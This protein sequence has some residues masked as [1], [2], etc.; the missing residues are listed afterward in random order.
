MEPTTL[1]MHFLTSMPGERCLLML[2]ETTEAAPLE[3]LLDAACALLPLLDGTLSNAEWHSAEFHKFF[4]K[5]Q[6]LKRLE[7][8][9]LSTQKRVLVTRNKLRG[10]SCNRTIEKKQCESFT[11]TC[12]LKRKSLKNS[13]QM[14]SY[15]F[16]KRC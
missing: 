3:H 6:D 11:F 10:Y 14:A 5:S 8:P 13:D 4:Q 15:K 2:G 9:H 7:N 1:C 16:C 12:H